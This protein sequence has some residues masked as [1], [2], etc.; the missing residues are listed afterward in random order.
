MFGEKNEQEL[1]QHDVFFKK[2]KEERFRKNKTK[3]Q[4]LKSNSFFKTTFSKVFLWFVCSENLEGV[5]GRA[6]L[7]KT[8]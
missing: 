1:L 8:F 4:F 6:T 7:E 3:M 2:K 5:L